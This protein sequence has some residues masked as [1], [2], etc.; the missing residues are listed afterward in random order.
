MLKIY[1]FEY[2]AYHC[3]F[4]SNVELLLFPIVFSNISPLSTLLTNQLNLASR[5]KYVSACPTYMNFE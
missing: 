1:Y 2:L 5:N 3:F 4:S